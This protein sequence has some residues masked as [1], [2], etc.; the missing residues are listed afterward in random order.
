M[1]RSLYVSNLALIRRLSVDFEEGF[2][3]LTG[4]TG[5][6]KSLVLDSLNL[7]LQSK[8]A[9]ELVRHG[10]EKLEVSLYFDEISP[11]A[12][13]EIRRVFP[14]EDEEREITLMRSVTCEG[15]SLCKC[16]GRTVSFSVA[17]AVAGSLISIH[18][19]MS[20]VGLMDE[21]NHRFYLDCGLSAEGAACLAE[22]RLL[23]GEYAKAKREK[24]R[25][26]SE[27]GNEKEMI[28]LYDYQ[29]KEIAKVKPKAGEEEALE[30]KLRELQAFEKN[31]AALKTA[32]RAL[33]GGEKGRGAVFLLEAA[34]GKLEHL[35]ESNPLSLYSAELYDMARRAKE[36][37]EEV[38]RAMSADGEEDPGEAMD[39]IRRR[40]DALYRLKLRYGSTVEEVLAYYGELKRKKDLT[41]SRKDDIKKASA[42]LSRLEGELMQKAEAL[43]S[44][45]RLAAETLEEGV[46]S[47]LRFLDMPK[48]RFCVMTEPIPP[49]PDGAE[50]IR[51]A[52]S[53]N[54]GEGLRPLS[55]IA[56]G[57][58]MSRIML[59]LQ[60][61]MGRSR[62]ADSFVFDEI[63][64]GISGATAQK[65]GICLRELSRE[66]Q[67]FC[68]THSAQVATLAHRHFLVKKEEAE[69]RTETDLVL[70]SQEEALAESARLLSGVRV[71]SAALEAAAKLRAEGLSE[72]ERQS[73][74]PR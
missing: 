49:G 31:Y 60:L 27:T 4:E 9:K 38:S 53:P 72:R 1:L 21:K 11:D 70:L 68:V 34:A 71:G 55:A 47:V 24:E 35:D 22:Y 40:L 23:Y 63:D 18:G 30:E 17:S 12:R 42:L 14:L 51:F 48:I 25:L 26:E 43:A 10:T 29:M 28:S 20:A 58:E 41:L 50:S 7:F 56:S 6:G 54:T 15:K 32:D 45:R 13:E 57:G 36:M 65:I 64:T 52:I 66:K 59:A 5:A 37:A 44:H 2:T 16:N 33:S 3:V 19:Q 73:W 67:V 69:G 61:K 46:L 8:G 74:I 62:S 39:R